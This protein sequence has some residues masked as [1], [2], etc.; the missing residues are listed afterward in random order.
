MKFEGTGSF[1]SSEG[2][3]HEQA[4]TK[5]NQSL[6]Q[7]ITCQQD[8]VS[9]Y[10]TFVMEDRGSQVV[11]DHIRAAEHVR[12]CVNNLKRPLKSVLL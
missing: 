3:T 1:V 10:K 4:V 9:C 11:L 5:F 2:T 12:G 7:T 8:V 6:R